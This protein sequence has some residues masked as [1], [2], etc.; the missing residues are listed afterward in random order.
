MAE[1]SRRSAGWPPNRVEYVHEP[2]PGLAAAR[3]CALNMA[4]DADVLVFIDDDETPSAGWLYALVLE[5]RRWSCSA[6]TGPVRAMFDGQVDQWIVC[7]GV[8]DRRRHPTGTRVAGAATNNLLLDIARVREMRLAIDD[9]SGLTGGEDTMFV[10]DLLRR[11]G[12]I[13]WCDEAE[14]YEP[15][16]PGRANRRWVMRRSFRAGTTWSR[17]ALLLE[18][19]RAHRSTKRLELTARDVEDHGRVAGLPRGMLS[20]NLLQRAQAA[21]ATTS[22]AGMLARRVRLPV[23]RIPTV[24]STRAAP[25]RTWLGCGAD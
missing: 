9:L 21:C 11:G 12:T 15:V 16:H 3:N 25:A 17:V 13:R 18:S 20:Q 24:S 4:R 23:L 14:V 6:V 1:R 10:H 8:Y 19:S 7:S 2:T 5:W 22:G